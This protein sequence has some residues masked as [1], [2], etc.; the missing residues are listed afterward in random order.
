MDELEAQFTRNI[1]QCGVNFELMI[2]GKSEE[3]V[4]AASRRL[5]K[6]TSLNFLLQIGADPGTFDKEEREEYAVSLR[7]N[8][9]V[10]WTR[11]T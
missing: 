1:G 4:A 6:K 2:D 9:T 11:R 5:N 8:G 10:P 7:Q 3:P